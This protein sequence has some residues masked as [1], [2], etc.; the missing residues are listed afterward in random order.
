MTRPL[1]D[2]WFLVTIRP[3]SDFGHLWKGDNE[4]EARAEMKRTREAG[5]IGASLWINDPGKG[6]RAIDVGAGE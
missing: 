2:N 1:P 5:H 3:R 6:L 4:F